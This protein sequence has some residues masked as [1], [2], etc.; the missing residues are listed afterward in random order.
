M[1][2]ILTL[3]TFDNIKLITKN[4]Q[5][6][7]TYAFQFLS[8]WLLKKN[9]ML[10]HLTRMTTSVAY[11]KQT[12]VAECFFSSCIKTKNIWM[13]DFGIRHR[14]I[15]IVSTLRNIVFGF[16]NMWRYIIKS[17]H[18]GQGKSLR[19]ET[20]SKSLSHRS[21]WLQDI[22]D[23]VPPIGNVKLRLVWL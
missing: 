10:F 14:K 16:R 12:T 4:I 5:S 15:L 1:N 7:S 23:L 22:Y 21:V 11:V 20:K 3:V 9:W 8:V 19:V 18:F 17:N 2:K 6:Y 13:K